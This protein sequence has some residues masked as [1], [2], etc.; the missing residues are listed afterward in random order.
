MGVEDNKKT[1]QLVEEAYNRGDLGSLD[2]YF[3]PKFDNSMAIPPGVPT[4]LEMAKQMHQ[5]SMQAFPDRKTEIVETIGEGNKVMAR[6][7]T[8]GTNKGGVP[9]IAAPAN[10]AKIDFEWISIFEFD[11][12]GK[13]TKHYGLNDI[14]SLGIQLG[15][16]T[17]PA[18]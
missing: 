12:G 18:M 5:M 4:G 13:I 8:T 6:I 2:Q 14:Y 17:P 9:W 1:V 10:N 7:H 11:N 16:I 15:V 3:S